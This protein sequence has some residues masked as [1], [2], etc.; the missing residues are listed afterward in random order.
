MSPPLVGGDLAC[1]SCHPKEA[2]SQPDTSM[3][4]ALLLP[5]SNEKI[6]TQGRV[7]FR[8]DA[9]TYTIEHVDGKDVYIVTDGSS[10]LSVPIHWTFGIQWQTYV[11]EHEGQLYESRVSSYPGINGLDITMGDQKS[12]PQGYCRSDGPSDLRR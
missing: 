4:Y 10:T 12:H 3:A 6:E 7:S 11:L 1:A 5:G 8:D 2:H 9:Y